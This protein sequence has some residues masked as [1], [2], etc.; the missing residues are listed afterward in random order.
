MAI[1]FDDRKGPTWH[2]IVGRNF[3]SFVTHGTSGSVISRCVWTFSR[4]YGENYC[5]QGVGALNVESSAKN[6]LSNTA[7]ISS[8]TQ[9]TTANSSQK[10]ST[11]STFTSATVPSSFSRRSKRLSSQVGKEGKESLVHGARSTLSVWMSVPCVGSN[12]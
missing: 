2:C 10:R 4:Y 11:S 7:P 3:G 6:E 12:A 5:V 1:Q 9:Y 8:A